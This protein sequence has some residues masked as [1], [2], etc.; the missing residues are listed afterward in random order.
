MKRLFAVLFVSLY[1]Y[2]IAGY[3]VVFSVLQH[4]VRSEV[5]QMLK[6]RIP[7]SDFVKFS[8]HTRALEQ[9]SY[10]LRWIDDH[11][12]TLDGKLYDV[13]RSSTVGDSTIL[14]CINDIQE[15]QLFANLDNHVQRQMGHSGQPNKLDSFKDVFKDSFFHHAAFL[16]ILPA[17]E[18]IEIFAAQDYET[19]AHDAPFLPPRSS[20]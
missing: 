3:L 7:D 19:V 5:K 6:A 12:F 13:V 9:H 15:E 18:P 10:S 1:L 11:E 2:N 20:I 17:I 16:A 8:F 14:L 4:R